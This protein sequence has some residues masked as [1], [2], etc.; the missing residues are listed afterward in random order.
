M[1]PCI[2]LAGV[3]VFCQDAVMDGT[4]GDLPGLFSRRGKQNELVGAGSGTRGCEGRRA[5]QE[6]PRGPALLLPLPVRA[7]P[8]GS[9]GPLWDGGRA[10]SQALHPPALPLSVN[11]RRIL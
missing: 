11:R 8:S 3:R 9:G 6:T 7:R 4:L 10:L 5:Q 1:T 2:P